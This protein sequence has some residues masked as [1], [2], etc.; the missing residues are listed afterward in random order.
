MYEYLYHIEWHDR[1][2][3]SVRDTSDTWAKNKAAVKQI[4]GRNIILD[5]CEKKK[6]ENG[7]LVR[8]LIS[9]IN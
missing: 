3:L 6:D 9:V 1:Y 5:S 2:Q 8:R 7:K 4:Y